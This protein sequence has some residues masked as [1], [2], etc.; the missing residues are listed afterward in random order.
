MGQ[1]PYT[2]KEDIML[3][4]DESRKFQEYNLPL[5]KVPSNLEQHLSLVN[6]ALLNG[7]FCI[8]TYH[9][10]INLFRI[11]VY[12]EGSEFSDLKISCTLS[13][14]CEEISTLLTTGN[15]LVSSHGVLQFSLTNSTL[16]IDMYSPINKI[17]A[18]RFYQI[19]HALK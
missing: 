1:V 17:M 15:F 4:I 5:K 16:H 9:S 18:E 3:A 2:I 12:E 10:D 8:L 7:A 6:K 11:K 14:N 19:T 13:S